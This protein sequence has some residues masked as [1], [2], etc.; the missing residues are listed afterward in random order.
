MISKGVVD[1]ILRQCP[2][3]YYVGRDISVKLTDDTTSAYF[4]LKDEIHISFNNI[5]NALGDSY[6]ECTEDLEEIIRTLLYHEC[7]HAIYTPLHLTEVGRKYMSTA[8][9][10]ED[11]RIET[12]CRTYFKGVNFKKVLLEINGEPEEP[13]SPQEEVFN[14]FRYGVGDPSLLAS[15]SRI[16]MDNIFLTR[17]N[18]CY[19]YISDI[20]AIHDKIYKKWK[21]DEQEDQSN[22]NEQSQ[23]DADN[24]GG[25]SN[26]EDNTDTNDS[27]EGASE[28]ST[29]TS[30]EQSPVQ[31]SIHPLVGDHDL[32]KVKI[33]CE[34]NQDDHVLDTYRDEELDKK[35]SQIF[36]NLN[37]KQGSQSSAINSYSG[38]FEPRLAG[39]EDY[40][41]FVQKSRQ[42]H[43]KAYSKVVLNLY[44][45]VSGSMWGSQ[46][47]LNS[48]V[49]SLVM[50]SKRNPDFELNIV[51]VGEGERKFDYN[52]ESYIE[53]TGGN[54]LDCELW[55]IAKSL[56]KPQSVERSLVLFDGLAYEGEHEAKHF[57]A[58]NNPHVSIISDTDNARAIS[59]YAPSAKTTI[60]KSDYVSK[61]KAEVIR[62]MEELFR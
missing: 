4:P 37:K 60:I 45:D 49:R 27:G 19:K 17:T 48:I 26:N 22:S 12:L 15:A 25:N 3:S 36:N 54:N 10:I 20:R 7:A 8:N 1:Q 14:L 29:N 13:K 39:R 51:L 38:V 18:A 23:D 52:K 42:G 5:A 56:R 55:S 57:G 24:D 34:Y 44:I 59:K 6:K 47:T 50:C 28:E 2:I 40:R 43:M 16:I 11:E 58:F 30:E 61:L 31:V 41:F 9:I 62:T 46:D 21:D 32:N 33:K 35:F 53:C